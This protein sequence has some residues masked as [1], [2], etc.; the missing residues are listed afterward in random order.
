[1]FLSPRYDEVFGEQ[2]FLSVHD[3]STVTDRQAGD[4]ACLLQRLHT[5]GEQRSEH[6]LAVTH[7]EIRLHTFQ[8]WTKSTHA[9]EGRPWTPR[10]LS[11]EEWSRDHLPESRKIFFFF[12]LLSGREPLAI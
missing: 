3:L 11:G 9:R 12:F 10:P 1:M 6:I 2:G 7:H 4:Q 8:S 5:S